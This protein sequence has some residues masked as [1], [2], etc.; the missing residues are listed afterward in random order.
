[1]SKLRTTCAC[2]FAAAAIIAV[3]SPAAAN[4][5]VN[6]G[7]EDPITSDG[8][9]FVGY[10]EGFN[11]GNTAIAQ[12]ST[13]MPLSGSQSLEL[14]IGGE[15]NTFAGVFQDVPGLL[16]GQTGIFGGWHKSLGDAGGIEIRIEWRDSNGN[17]E[18]SRTPNFVPTPGQ[19]YEYFELSA[20]VPAGADTARVVYAIQSFGAPPNQT[21]YVDDTSFLVPEPTSSSLMVVAGLLLAAFR[22]RP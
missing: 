19:E 10:W 16:A 20:A 13:L 22:R 12:N 7:F 5:L 15:A 6:P 2:A 11:G 18:I 4:L 17:T 8:A 3:T 14:L 21:V 9:P 1:M